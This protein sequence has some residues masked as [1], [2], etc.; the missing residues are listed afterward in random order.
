MRILTYTDVHISTK[1]SIINTRG[2]KYS[3]RLESCIKSVNWA[4]NLADELNCDLI[5]CLGDFFDKPHLTAE[6]IT[7]VKEINWSNLPHKFI[8]GNH[9]SDTTSL[10]FNSV[11]RIRRDNIE[12][13]THPK[14]D[15]YDN[16]NLCYIPYITEDNRLP[17][18]KYL[19]NN[20]KSNLVFSHND[21]KGLQAGLFKTKEGFDLHDIDKK[22]RLYLNGHLH[23][24]GW[25][26]DRGLNVGNLTGKGFNEDSSLY[27]HGVYILDTDTWTIEFVENPYAFNFYKLIIN[28][29]DDLS[30]LDNLL[31]NSVV[32]IT[33]YEYMLTDVRERITPLVDSGKVIAWK[34]NLVYSYSGLNESSE[35]ESFTSIDPIQQFVEYIRE[36]TEPSDMLDH[37][38]SKLMEG[39]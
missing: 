11:E 26:S 17:L 2:N 21:V 6:E 19:L 37:E 36:I 29:T 7:A 3:T 38:L 23:N 39:R 18:D 33:C 8:I 16:Y 35:F 25:F 12:I 32:R 28:S 10:V 13:I 9:D 30:K 14:I 5:I 20:G 31:N 15:E 27:R 1:S 4:E 34:P 22:C 24:G